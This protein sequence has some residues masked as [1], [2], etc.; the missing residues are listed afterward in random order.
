MAHFCDLLLRRSSFLTFW[1][2]AKEIWVVINSK[3]DVQ[4]TRNHSKIN[5]S[6]E[7][8]ASKSGVAPKVGEKCAALKVGERC[9]A[10][11]VGAK[12]ASHLT[13]LH[14]AFV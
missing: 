8:G 7:V 14:G 4:R 12:P 3:N 11:K 9:A 6:T 10:L 5:H 13:P 1:C 2:G